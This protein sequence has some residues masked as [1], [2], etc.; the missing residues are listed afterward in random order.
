MGGKRVHSFRQFRKAGL[1]LLRADRFTAR[2]TDRRLGRGIVREVAS[3]EA[4]DYPG[5]L[6]ETLLGLWF[7]GEVSAT[8]LV[9]LCLL[10]TK[11]KGV[12]VEDLARELKHDRNSSRVV[13]KVLRG[14]DVRRD[15]LHYTKIA[16]RARNGRT[17]TK[18]FVPTVPFYEVLARK[19]RG[20]E[21]E[22]M[23]H[24]GQPHLLCD[25]YHT[26]EIVTQHGP[27]AVIPARLFIDGAKLDNQAST[28][29]VHRLRHVPTRPR[30]PKRAPRWPQQG[31]K[32]GRAL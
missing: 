10:I 12:G 18:E 6:R 11:S 14:D 25:N 22:I 8:L 27:D 24:R 20:E 4:P 7:S 31:P 3:R 15:C 2:S 28:L 19:W 32:T 29:N 23:L 1:E 9:R 5:Q 30:L 21:S 26:H 13:Y 16:V 17:A